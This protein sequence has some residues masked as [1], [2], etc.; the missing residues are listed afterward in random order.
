M[1][2]ALGQTVTAGEKARIWDLPSLSLMMLRIGCRIG[3]CLASG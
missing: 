3:E 1:G 2:G